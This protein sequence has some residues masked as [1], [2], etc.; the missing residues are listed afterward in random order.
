MKVGNP[1]R[2]HRELRNAVLFRRG[3]RDRTKT[4]KPGASDWRRSSHGD[5]E[6][7]NAMGDLLPNLRRPNQRNGDTK[8]RC[9]RM[10]N[11]PNPIL[12]KKK[13]SA[14]GKDRVNT[15][16]QKKK[17]GLGWFSAGKI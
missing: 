2:L 6:G 13:E 17:G 12:G 1:D 15:P 8:T 11:R 7:E 16:H 10:R 3:K 5:E 4:R 14:G 9:N